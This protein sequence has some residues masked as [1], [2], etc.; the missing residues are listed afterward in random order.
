MAFAVKEFR[1][2]VL[3]SPTHRSGGEV[4]ADSLLA[5][6]EV[7]QL[8]MAMLVQEHVLRLQIPEDNVQT[9]EILKGQE[10]LT[11][12]EPGATLGET[13]S[14]AEVEEELPTR[15]VVQDQVKPSV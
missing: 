12:V 4:V 15:A 11:G 9:V 10:Q 14:T 7:R 13:P 2:Q 8:G 6:P 5:E 1:G 3:R